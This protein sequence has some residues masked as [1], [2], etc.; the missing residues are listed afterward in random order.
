MSEEYN[1]PSPSS[2]EW[3]FSKENLPD[4]QVELC[5]RHEY[6]REYYLAQGENDD[7]V[8]P[9][10]QI[11][12]D[13][14]TGPIIGSLH[15][16]SEREVFMRAG[17]ETDQPFHENPVF[18]SGAV[19]PADV[20]NLEKIIHS[21]FSVKRKE[22]VVEYLGTPLVY[23]KSIG[24]YTRRSYPGYFFQKIEPAMT[25]NGLV[26]VFCLNT[27]D[28]GEQELVEGFKKYLGEFAG[29]LGTG[30]GPKVTAFRKRLTNL[31][32]VRIRHVLPFRD[33]IR[34]FHG[35]SYLGREFLNREG[36][37]YLEEALN[38]RSSKGRGENEA[39]VEER[40]RERRRLVLKCFHKENPQAAEEGIEPACFKEK[41]LGE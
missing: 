8:I 26:A 10:L 22:Q 25:Q 35:N 11:P 12:L 15:H 41:A 6:R 24:E 38:N 28:Y 5:F 27:K 1:L 33:S 31:A 14:R 29:E 37:S 21:A 36:N 16:P 19:V 4:E 34:F 30:R 7:S 3:D 23:D 2:E 13:N 39:K 18:R 32:I 9:F 20:L 17:P 40:L